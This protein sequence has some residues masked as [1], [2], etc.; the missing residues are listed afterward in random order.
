MRTSSRRQKCYDLVHSPLY[1][2]AHNGH[3]FVTEQLIEA[4]CN[5][6]VRETE[7][8]T[9]RERGKKKILNLRVLY[10]LSL[11]LALLIHNKQYIG[12]TRFQFM[13]S[14]TSELRTNS[15]HP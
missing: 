6:D 4:R 1:I 5:I 8:G 14:K 9:V 11:A 13:K 15:V 3:A 12:V 10:L 7:D 2:A